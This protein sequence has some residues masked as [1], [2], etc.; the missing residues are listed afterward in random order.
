MGRFKNKT[1]KHYI[2]DLEV[3]NW[4]STR[5]G[6]RYKLNLVYAYRK[7]LPH[8]RKTIITAPLKKGTPSLDILNE[9]WKGGELDKIL[10]IEWLNNSLRKHRLVYRYYDNWILYSNAKTTYWSHFADEQMITSSFT[11][12]PE[13]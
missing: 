3:Q 8:K 9:M 2:V 11:V 13:I 1:K 6:N 12:N 4:E 5:S 7:N 10:V